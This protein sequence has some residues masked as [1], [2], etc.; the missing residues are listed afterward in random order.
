M[1]LACFII[2]N[3]LSDL[4]HDGKGYIDGI[5]CM[6]SSLMILQ[7]LASEV[8]GSAKERVLGTI[9]ASLLSGINSFIFGQ[10]YLT[11]F[12]SIAASAYSMSALNMPNAIR[13]ATSTAAI[14]TASGFIS[15]EYSSIL[16]VVMRSVNTVIGVGFSVLFVLLSYKLKVRKIVLHNQENLK[17]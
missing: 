12:A 15:P 1:G 4:T 6:L 13:I 14:I 9:I 5:W 16:N 17:R 7:S 2:G 10:S 11:I 3:M 8:I